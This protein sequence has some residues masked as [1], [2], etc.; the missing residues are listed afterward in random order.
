MTIEPPILGCQASRK[1]Q[2][3]TKKLLHAKY[4]SRAAKNSQGQAV[5]LVEMEVTFP[6]MMPGE[7]KGR[8]LIETAPF[9]V[10][11]HNVLVF[12]EIVEGWKGGAFFAMQGMYYKQ[13]RTW[14]LHGAPLRSRSI[15]Q[16]IPT[17][18]TP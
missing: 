4:G 3:V 8:I 11:P 10:N 2:E 9:D 18:S 16:S 7:R 14:R 1:L 12:L 17:P 13:R 6:A 5:M 15:L